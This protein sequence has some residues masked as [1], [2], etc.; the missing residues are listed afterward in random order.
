MNQIHLWTASGPKEVS[1]YNSP[2]KDLK[3][4]QEDNH[5]IRDTFTLNYRYIAD[6]LVNDYL[7]NILRPHYLVNL[8]CD[9]TSNPIVK[10]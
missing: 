6:I 8:G 4:K 7:K 2:Q 9:V 10:D 5:T 3:I 1:S